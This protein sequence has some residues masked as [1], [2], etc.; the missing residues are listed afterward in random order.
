MIPEEVTTRIEE[1]RQAIIDGE[2]VVPA[3]NDEIKSF[4]FPE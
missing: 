1:L 4:K 3:S 2:I